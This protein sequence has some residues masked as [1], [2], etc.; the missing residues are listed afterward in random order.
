MWVLGCWL[1]STQKYREQ[2]VFSEVSKWAVI[3]SFLC[4]WS[5][6]AD[7]TWSPLVTEFGLCSSFAKFSWSESYGY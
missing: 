3:S 2:M 5:T 4:L 1:E 7:V 6:G